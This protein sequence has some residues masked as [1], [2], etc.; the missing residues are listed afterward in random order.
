MQPVISIKFDNVFGLSISWGQQPNVDHYEV[1]ID[2]H[3]TVFIQNTTY[4]VS[5]N[6]LIGT[7]HTVRIKVVDR[8][9]RE[10]ETIKTG[11]MCNSRCSFNELSPSRTM[12]TITTGM[13]YFISVAIK[14]RNNDD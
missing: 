6:S 8:C 3:P 12:C 4:N 1:Q 11:I 14:V 2:E 9:H 7:N 5:C 13:C 10:N